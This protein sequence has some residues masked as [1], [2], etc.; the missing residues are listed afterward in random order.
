VFQRASYYILRPE[1]LES[2]MILYRT[3]GDEVYRERGWE[4]FQALEK[5][6]RVDG[7]YSGLNDVRR[8][9]G[10]RIDRMETFFLAETLKYLYLL[11]SPIDVIPMDQFVFNTEAHPIPIFTPPKAWI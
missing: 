6:T 2:L 7:G 4:I 1:T 9:N 5:E 11:F 3:T 8:V 10:T